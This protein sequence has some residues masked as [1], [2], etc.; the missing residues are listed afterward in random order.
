MVG[1]NAKQKELET[2]MNELAK[3]EKQL[4]DSIE[5]KARL[6]GEVRAVGC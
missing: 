6:E 3:L 1:L 4:S 2:L 5:E